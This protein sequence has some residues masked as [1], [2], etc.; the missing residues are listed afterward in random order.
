MFR[1]VIIFV[2]FVVMLG[3]GV[4][5]AAWPKTTAPVT[6]GFYN[7]E[8][9]MHAYERVQTGMPVS[10]LGTAGFDIAKAQRMSKLAL[11]DRY[12]PKDSSAFDALDPAVQECYIGRDDCTAYIFTSMGVDAVLLVEGGRVAWKTLSGMSVAGKHKGRVAMN[13]R[14]RPHVMAG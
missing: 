9:L 10:Q 8:R 11:M 2:G 12:M 6:A 1:T 13:R 5:V 4:A 7:D 14:A 3:A